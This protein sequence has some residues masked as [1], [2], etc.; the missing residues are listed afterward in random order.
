LIAFFLFGILQACVTFKDVDMKKFGGVKIETFTKEEIRISISANIDNPNNYNIKVKKADL[1]IYVDG[2]FLGKAHIDKKIVL[3]KKTTADYQAIIVTDLRKAGSSLMTI[4][5]AAILKG[6]AEI[7]V[8]G[9]VKAGVILFSR[10]IPI[11]EKK[12]IPLTQ[13]MLN[14]MGQ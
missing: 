10:K 6:E 5:G 3:K 14:S 9:K 13:D 7:R 12:N 2:K 4:A 8:K 11:D 1:E